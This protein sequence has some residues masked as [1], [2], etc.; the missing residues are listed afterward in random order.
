MTCSYGGWRQ[1]SFVF[2]FPQCKKKRRDSSA[3]FCQLF[4]F[5]FSLRF[6][7]IF[8]LHIFFLVFNPRPSQRFFSALW[9]PCLCGILGQTFFFW[10]FCSTA[11][12]ETGGNHVRC[13][14][15]IDGV[16]NS[17][18]SC[19]R[20]IG[21]VRRGGRIVV[22]SG[23]Y[24]RL[25]SIALWHVFSGGE[26]VWWRDSIRIPGAWCLLI[27][28]LTRMHAHPSPMSVSVPSK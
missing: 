22:R 26:N 12:R 28:I 20:G 7:G 9:W 6:L 5:W 10:V 15:E 16:R 11:N 1:N 3:V 17:Q 18:N 21:L 8:L 2:V 24:D 14:L 23:L 19:R 13:F 4:S 25:Q 27:V